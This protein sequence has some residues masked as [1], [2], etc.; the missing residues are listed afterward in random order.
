MI[1]GKA[2]GIYD[3]LAAT[4]AEHAKPAGPPIRPS[5]ERHECYRPLVERYIR[6]Q[7]Q[8]VEVFVEQKAFE[9]G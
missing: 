6:L 8:L 5:A 9:D 4:A 1:A 3:D 7:G 2:A